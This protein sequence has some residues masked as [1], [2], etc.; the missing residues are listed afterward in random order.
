MKYR[1]FVPIL[2]LLSQKYSRTKY[3]ITGPSEYS[4]FYCLELQCFTQLT[5]RNP[6]IF[7]QNV[8][9]TVVGTLVKKPGLGLKRKCGDMAVGVGEDEF[10]F[11]KRVTLIR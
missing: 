9:F 7:S 6:S 4:C 1:K 5:S 11:I 3:L 2:L 10:G 8:K